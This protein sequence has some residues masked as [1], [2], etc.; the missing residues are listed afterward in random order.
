M[1]TFL[2]QVHLWSPSHKLLRLCMA[3]YRQDFTFTSETVSA[4][5]RNHQAGDMRRFAEKGGHQLFRAGVL[6]SVWDFSNLKVQAYRA[7]VSLCA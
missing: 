3:C 5:L 4:W 7:G 6:C 1:A 2:L